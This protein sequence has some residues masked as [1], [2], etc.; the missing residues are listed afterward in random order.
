MAAIKR[1]LTAVDFSEAAQTAARQAEE[2]ARALGAEL[3]VLHVLNE[4][5]FVPVE[6]SGYGPP[7]ITDEYESALGAKLA[8]IAEALASEGVKVWPKL[9]RG[10]PHDAIVST[11][12]SEHVDLIIMGTHG[13][14]GVSHLLLGSVAERVVRLSQ[15]PVMTIRT[16]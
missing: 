7:A 6:D 16:P 2:L 5:A 10:A 15:V 3:L 1:I 14:T 9:A 11:A 4:P 12:V 13:R 8:G